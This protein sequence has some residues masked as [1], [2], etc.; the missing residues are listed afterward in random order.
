[1]KHFLTKIAR[2][3]MYRNVVSFNYNIVLPLSG[4][5]QLLNVLVKKI[6]DLL[7]SPRIAKEKFIGI[8]INMLAFV[9]GKLAQIAPI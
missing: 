8:C 4:N 5:N 7:E 1:M 3:N 9:N 6:S 2:L